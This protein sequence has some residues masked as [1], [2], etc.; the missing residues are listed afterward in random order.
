M[1]E[2]TTL[3][4]ALLRQGAAAP[5]L[6]ERAFAWTTGRE[7]GSFGL[8]SDEP[9]Q[10]AI[11]RWSGLEERLASVSVLRLASAHQVHGAVV[12]EHAGTWRG[13]LR[14]RGVDG[15]FTITPGTALAV[16]VADCAP[17]F[18]SHPAGAVAALHAGWRGTAAR[19]VDVGLD[20]FA[21]RG[22][23]PAECSVH[24]GPAI[25]G[26]CYE[27]GA[28]VLAAVHGRPAV[29]NGVLD[30]RAELAQQASARG[31]RSVST[32]RD[33]TKCD[34]DRFFSH[35]AGDSGRQLGLIVLRP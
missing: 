32:S 6:G 31:V 21:Q 7:D 16:T 25:C 23:A 8:G 33:C 13:W 15:H 20:L 12:A 19:I 4:A 18:I 35:R 26:R 10:Y 28:E 5:D 29:A 17:V 22:F 3:P 11:N 9:V 14:M 34:N 30:I 2:R 1:G 27:V 24:L